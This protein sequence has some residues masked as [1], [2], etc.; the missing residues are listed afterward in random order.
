VVAALA[1]ARCSEPAAPPTPA[2]DHVSPPEALPPAPDDVV[3]EGR[4]LD[5]DGTP[6]PGWTLNVRGGRPDHWFARRAA[7]AA[8]G[9]FRVACPVSFGYWIDGA[10]AEG[11]LRERAM[12]EPSFFDRDLRAIRTVARTPDR[13]YGRVD[14]AFA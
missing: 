7:T 9:S 5:D 3:I 13:L 6:L 8:D 10:T 4:L 2:P 12:F 1:L 14:V 11:A